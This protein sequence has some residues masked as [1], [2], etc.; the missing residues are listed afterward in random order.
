MQTESLY[1]LLGLPEGTDIPR[2]RAAY[3]GAVSTAASRQDWARAKQLSAAFDRL[4]DPVRLA[5][6]PGR[7]RDAR[8]WEPAH[9]PRP[10]RKA[11]TAQVGSTGI[12]WRVVGST[13]LALGVAVLA[14]LGTWRHLHATSNSTPVSALTA[15][16]LPA[17]GSAVTPS[18]APSTILTGAPTTNQARTSSRPK[19]VTPVIRPT[20]DIRLGN[21]GHQI[22]GLPLRTTPPTVPVD[23]RGNATMRCAGPLGVTAWS[24]IDHRIAFT[25]PPGAAPEYLATP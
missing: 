4:P 19:A 9:P 14:G 21:T 13:A 8:R 12:R 5:M 11:R 2:L 18:A 6:Y 25:C 3:E 7:D 22:G 15:P 17:S 1:A 10:S 23:S 24:K 16:V 20:G